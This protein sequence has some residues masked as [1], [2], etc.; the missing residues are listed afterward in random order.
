MGDEILVTYSKV[1]PQFVKKR[2][3]FIKI[4]VTILF[5]SVVLVPIVALCETKKNLNIL[6]QYNILA[7][8]SLILYQGMFRHAMFVIDSM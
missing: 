5:L 1:S 3:Y 4:Q 7:K 2:K 6:L 8:I